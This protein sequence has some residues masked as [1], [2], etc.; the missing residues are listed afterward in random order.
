MASHKIYVEAL[1]G[2]T[3]ATTGVLSFSATKAR[4]AGNVTVTITN[5]GAGAG[6]VGVPGTISGQSIP[7]TVYAEP[8]T[9][10]DAMAVLA[11]S[12]AITGTISY[13]GF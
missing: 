4:P 8:S 10:G 7:I 13:E 12:T 2:D 6:F 3:A 9:A 1:S 5:T 11:T